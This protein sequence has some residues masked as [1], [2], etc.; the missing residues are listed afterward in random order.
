[1]NK[2]VIQ[3]YVTYQGGLRGLGLALD[4]FATDYSD[5]RLQSLGTD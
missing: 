2:E 5:D 1:M 4:L 3:H